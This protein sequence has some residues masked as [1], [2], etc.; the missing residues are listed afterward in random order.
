MWLT[1]NHVF[2]R[3]VLGKFTSFIFWNFKIFLVSLGIFQ[4]SKKVKSVNLSQI[5]Y[6]SMW[7]LVQTKS[8]NLLG[9][10]FD[11]KTDLQSH[12]DGLCSKASRK[13]HALARIAPYMDLRKILIHAFFDSQFNYSPLVWVCHSRTLNNKINELHERSLRLIYSGKTVTFQKLLVR[14]SSVSILVKKIQ[15]LSFEM[16]KV[17]D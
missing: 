5:S 8:Q 14:D 15:T 4:N 9:V 7:L 11:N 17:A 3:K 16:F 1:K 13:L 6:L 12:L 10:T 2:I